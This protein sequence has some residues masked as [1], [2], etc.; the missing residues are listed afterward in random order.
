M[1]SGEYEKEIRERE[2]LKGL[3]HNKDKELA[4][5]MIREAAAS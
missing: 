4:E 1:L 5:H 2:Y 3:E